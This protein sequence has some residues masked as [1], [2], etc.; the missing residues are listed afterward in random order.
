LEETGGKDLVNKRRHLRDHLIPALGKERLDKI[1]SMR[2]RQYR[3]ARRSAGAKV[4][5]INRE[6]STLSHLMRRASKEWGWMGSDAVP[7]FPMEREVRKKINILTLGQAEKLLQAA[8]E[9]HDPK[10]W[11]FVMFGLHTGMRHSEIV[12]RRFDEVD[13]DNNRIWIN[14]A[15]A[16]EREQPIT[17]SLKDALKRA[18]TQSTDKEGW[19][20]PAARKD[21]K[22]PHRPD[23]RDAFTRSVLRAGLNPKLCTPHVLRHTAI[24]R[25]VKAGTDLMTVKRISGHKT[26][27]MVEHYTHIHGNHIDA[28]MVALDNAAGAITHELHMGAAAEASALA[29]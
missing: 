16:G 27:A 19:I 20:F 25:L 26:T 2:L 8:I 29:A 6:L 7:T 23:M 1:S 9:D 21:T 4:A 12:A 11:L 15:K 13:F 3:A 28:A 10:A 17:P 18:R 24:T 5:T 14:R 22:G